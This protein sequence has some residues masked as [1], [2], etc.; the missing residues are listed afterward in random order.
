MIGQTLAKLREERDSCTLILP[1]WRGRLWWPMLFPDGRH[2]A[3]FVTDSR[4]LPRCH[5]MFLLGTAAGNEAGVGA[6]SWPAIALRLDFS[7]SAATR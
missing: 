1:L 5:D 4:S 7:D 6:P 3:P 2:P